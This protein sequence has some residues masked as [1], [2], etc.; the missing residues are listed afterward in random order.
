MQEIIDVL[1]VKDTVLMPGQL[2]SFDLGKEQSVAA[3]THALKQEQPVFVVLQKDA[4]KEGVITSEDLYTVGTVA[5][6]TKM[7][8]DQT[9]V[10]RIRLLGLYI[11]EVQSY[12][13]AKDQL[14][15]E[16]FVTARTEDRISL[17]E[18]ESYRREIISRAQAFFSM[19]DKTGMRRFQELENIRSLSELIYE[20]LHYVDFD[21]KEKQKIIDEPAL[22]KRAELLGQLMSDFIE[23]GKMRYE[24]SEKMRTRIDERQKQN[25]YREQIDIL[26]KELGEEGDDEASD[27]VSY[28][29][30][31]EKLSA[32]EQIREKIEKTIKRFSMLSPRNSEAA[33]L[34]EYIEIMLSVPWNTLKKENKNIKKAERILQKDHYG[35][36]KIKERI[37]EF[38]AVHMAA[39][40][41]DAPILCLVGPPGTG[42]TSIVKSIA[43]ALN[44]DYERICLGGVKDEAEIRGHRKTYV[45]AM[46]GRIV[47]AMRHV[48]NSN[49][50]LLLDEIDKMG[51]DQRGDISAAMLE[52]LDPAQ[53]SGFYDHYLEVPLDLSRVFFVA[54]A[55][56]RDQIPA[57]LLDRMEIIEV[58]SYL[59]QEKLEIAKQY[60]IPKQL[61]RHALTKEEV[62]FTKKAIVKLIRQYTKEAGVRNLER[63]IESILRKIV[64]ERLEEDTDALVKIDEETVEHY[65][66][67]PVS[68]TEKESKRAQTGLVHGL[69]YTSVGGATLDVEAIA[70]P[71]KGKVT[72]TGNM[73]DVMKESAQIAALTVR[74][75]LTS[76]EEQKF[77]E[78]H[79]IHLHIPEGAVPKDGP[80]AGI[81][82]ATAVY[83]AVTGQKVDGH[84]AMTGELS[85]LGRV[86]P[87]GGLREKVVAAKA[88]GIKKIIVPKQNEKNIATLPEPVRRDMEFYYVDT[89]AQVLELVLIK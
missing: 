17:M 11:A 8:S 3:V 13:T 47:S 33:V 70:I 83:S 82:M 87:I 53:N 10:M 74:S 57:P 51:T 44:R 56:R 76:E 42:K 29:K 39:P 54:T 2:T 61:K 77:F 38:L 80:S 27:A 22:L 14:H 18:S 35:L 25:L 59:E 72:F 78:T 40:D 85:L 28:Q 67:T 88:A 66:E 84:V 19:E 63:S 15:L 31:L 23:I 89:L 68:E 36:T 60:L 71:G 7:P 6:I 4:A 65:L 86:L 20:V 5:K 24:I 48:G 49:P 45:G 75:L 52:V 62:R 50:V 26:K 46:P 55:N 21:Y 69:A 1:A 79:D 34:Q 32:P 12:D 64:K 37:V 41:A 58:N 73:G 16:A 9:G 43:R 30:Q 81:T